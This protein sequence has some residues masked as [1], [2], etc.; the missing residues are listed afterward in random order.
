MSTVMKLIVGLGNPEEKYFNTRHNTGFIVLDKLAEKLLEKQIFTGSAI[1]QNKFQKNEDLEG[2]LLKYDD[3]L[4]LKPLTYMNNSGNAVSKTALFYKIV[5]E[6]IYI[7]HDD[8]DLKL[9]DYKIQQGVG[10]KMHNG[11]M[12]IEQKIGM[13]NFWRA[14]IGVDNRD[15]ENRMPGEAYVLQNFSVEEKK[16]VDAVIEKAVDDII[17]RMTNIVR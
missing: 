11:V 10:P 13:K 7:I 9:G 17:L 14:R 2:Q 8:L 15:T 1:N 16:I 4:L 5:T 6:D 3:M 12:S